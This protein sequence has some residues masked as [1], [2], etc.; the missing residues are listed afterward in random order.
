MAKLADLRSCRQPACALC[1][2]GGFI[3]RT[4]HR[5]HAGQEEGLA[6]LQAQRTAE[7]PVSDGHPIYL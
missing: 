3:S 6:R 5:L 4:R 2:C 7:L 1:K